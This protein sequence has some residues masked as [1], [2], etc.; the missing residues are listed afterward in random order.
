MFARSL[1]LGASAT[2]NKLLMQHFT[3]FPLERVLLEGIEPNIEVSEGLFPTPFLC[4][5]S[6]RFPPQLQYFH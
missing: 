5:P 6:P 4:I 3:I 1:L 2:V